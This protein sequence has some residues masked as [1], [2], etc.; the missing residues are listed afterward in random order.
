MYKYCW[1]ETIR[2][3]N[4]KF[5]EK[6]KKF[7]EERN[8]G[9]MTNW[10][11][12]VIRNSIH[13][14]RSNGKKYIIKHV[15]VASKYTKFEKIINIILWIFSLFKMISITLSQTNICMGLTLPNLLS[16]CEVDKKI[17]FWKFDIWQRKKDLN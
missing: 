10:L 4:L 2:K 5:F 16:M 17:C 6:D 8:F 15:I 11:H 7:L 1:R 14:I 3:N 13:E 9:K 12:L